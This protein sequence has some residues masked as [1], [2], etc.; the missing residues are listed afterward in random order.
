MSTREELQKELRQGLYT[1][2]LPP[3]EQEKVQDILRAPLRRAT[4]ATAVDEKP[5]LKPTIPSVPIVQSTLQ[6]ESAPAQSPAPPVIST[7]KPPAPQTLKPTP[8]AGGGPKFASLQR[9]D[10]RFRQDQVELLTSMELQLRRRGTR[11]ERMT[12]ASL[13][14]AIVD[15]L[16]HLNLE[17]DNLPDEEALRARIF[18]KLGLRISQPVTKTPPNA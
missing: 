9:I 16:P 3:S 12:K 1:L 11:S 5:A 17:W 10:V 14:R 15:V 2:D 8:V 18:K 6:K 13:V 4:Q 7:A